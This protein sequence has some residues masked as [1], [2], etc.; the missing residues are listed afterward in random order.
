MDLNY[1]KSIKNIFC[2]TEEKPEFL[3]KN[4]KGFH[5]IFKRKMKQGIYRYSKT[6][7]FENTHSKYY[8]CILDE[9]NLF[10]I[11]IS[12]IDT[13]TSTSLKLSVTLPIDTRIT[14]HILGEKEIILADT[15]FEN[16]NRANKIKVNNKLKYLESDIDVLEFI[17][18]QILI[19]NEWFE[20]D[21]HNNII[22]IKEHIIGLE[23]YKLKLKS[24]KKLLKMLENE[25]TYHE[26]EHLY[27]KTK[28]ES[29]LTEEVKDIF[30]F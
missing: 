4:V 8:T 5:R 23:S 11:K 16:N 26:K 3:I 22:K 6:K 2:K 21:L 25:W 14:E 18:S 20:K 17:D 1:F 24:H 28:D 29:F 13:S 7:I 19:I 27:S 15:I 30:L 10:N 9:N 12:W